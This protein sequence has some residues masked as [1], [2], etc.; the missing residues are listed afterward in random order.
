MRQRVALG[1]VGVRTTST[2]ECAS[3]EKASVFGV[4][5]KANEWGRSR[6]GSVVTTLYEGVSRYCVV[7]KFLRVENKEFAH[8]VWLTKPKYPYAPNPLVV[9]V[10]VMAPLRQQEM[11][12]LVPLTRIAPTPVIVEPENDGTHFYMLRVKGFDRIGIS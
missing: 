8:V 2:T 6:C 10:R 5:V 1:T 4:H 12:C 9:R 3:F 7:K 11:C